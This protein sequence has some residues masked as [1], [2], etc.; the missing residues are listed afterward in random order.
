M[1]IGLG[2]NI[3]TGVG[4]SHTPKDIGVTFLSQ[5]AKLECVGREERTVYVCSADRSF[6]R[7]CRELRTAK[8]QMT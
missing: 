5:S 6:R 1:G 7:E 4:A 3:D 8:R 2:S